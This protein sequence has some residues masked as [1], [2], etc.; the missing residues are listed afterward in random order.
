ADL[1]AVRQLRLLQLHA[2]AV[3]HLGIARVEA[4]HPHAAPVGLPQALDAL[5][6]GGLAGTVAPG[7][8]EDLAAPGGEGHIL[9]RH[10]VAVTLPQ[11]LNIDD[12]HADNSRDRR[13]AAEWRWMPARVG[14]TTPLA[15]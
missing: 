6:R 2:E 8:A 4:Q 11:L 7:D 13:G 12:C 9:H 10:A 3:A 1:D 5:D 15:R 14:L